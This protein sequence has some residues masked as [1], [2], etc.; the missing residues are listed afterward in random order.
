MR[1]PLQMMYQIG[2]SVS[3]AQRRSSATRFPFPTISVGGITAGGSGKTPVVRMIS[4]KLALLNVDPV[5]ISRGYGKKGGKANLAWIAGRDPLPDPQ[6]FG[7]EPSMLAS[8]MSR[9]AVLVGSDR[10]RGIRANMKLLQTMHQPV[11]LL[12]DGFQHVQISRDL[13]VVVHD[14]DGDHRGL[15]PTGRLREPESSLSRADILLV[16]TRNRDPRLSAWE[17]RFRVR[18]LSITLNS[19]P[20]IAWMGEGA[21]VRERDF[22]LI[23]GIAQPER[24][25]ASVR[26]HDLKIIGAS[27]FKDHHRYAER[28]ARS[29]L[30]IVEAHPGAMLLTTEKDVVKLSQFDALHPYLYYLP[31]NVSAGVEFAEIITRFLRSH[32]AMSTTKREGT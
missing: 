18:A 15:L 8:T 2:L 32:R 13:D 24:F 22:F 31:Y 23:S 10:I 19:A 3:Q 5:I 27:T 4:E 17:E 14:P 9:G 26:D 30:G 6:L 7:D 21:E 20:P 25:H 1:N 16:P 29:I 11:L 12:D 28:D